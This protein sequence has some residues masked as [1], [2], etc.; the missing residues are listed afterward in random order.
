MD[1]ALHILSGC[2]CPI[3]RGM[4]TERHEP[5]CLLHKLQAG[6]WK[7]SVANTEYDD[8]WHLCQHGDLIRW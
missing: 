8:D 6:S 3:I 4:V 2:Q 7:H 1:S 5:F